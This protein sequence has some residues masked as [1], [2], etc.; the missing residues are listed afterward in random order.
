MCSFILYLVGDAFRAGDVSNSQ[1]SSSFE[2]EAQ[3]SLSSRSNIF[4]LETEHANQTSLE[5]EKVNTG[6]NVAVSSRIR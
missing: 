1:T 2:P 5:A 3:L 4:M 6:K